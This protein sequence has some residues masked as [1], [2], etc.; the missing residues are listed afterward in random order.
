MHP[1]VIGIHNSIISFAE[2]PYARRLRSAFEAI[3]SE[4]KE[5]LSKPNGWLG[6][7]NSELE[8]R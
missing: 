7:F 8:S 5:L 4:I 2:Y 3:R 6:E 1:T